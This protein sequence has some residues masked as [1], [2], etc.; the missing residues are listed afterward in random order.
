MKSG[1]F[2]LFAIVCGL[3]FCGLASFRLWQLWNVPAE[4]HWIPAHLAVPLDSTADRLELLVGGEPAAKV[5]AAQ[6]MTLAT[7]RGSGPMTP[8]DLTVRLNTYEKER[9]AT[10]PRMLALSAVAG[11]GLVLLV[12]GLLTPLIGSFRP[13][14]LVDINLTA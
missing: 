1:H 12:I 8:G 14:G 11:G 5:L 7:S 9:L 4:G 10:V 6:R 2:R 13:H 3:L